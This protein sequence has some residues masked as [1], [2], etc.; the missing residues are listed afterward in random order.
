MVVSDAMAKKL[1]PKKDAMGQ[2]V[3]VDADTVPCTYVV[4]IAE[5]IKQQHFRVGHAFL[6]RRHGHLDRL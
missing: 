6:H 2:C 1:W 4:G 5:N 3:R